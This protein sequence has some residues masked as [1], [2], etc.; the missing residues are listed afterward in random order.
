MIP[1]FKIICEY[2]GGLYMERKGGHQ[3]A[4]GARNDWAKSNEA[5][6]L[7]YFFLQFGPDEVRS[8][9]AMNTI[10]RAMAVRA[11]RP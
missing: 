6:M 4:T 10:K 5:Q 2:Q 3:S 11:A 9:E 7:G 8:G 1:E